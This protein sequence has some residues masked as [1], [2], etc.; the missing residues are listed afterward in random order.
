MAFKNE[1]RDKLLWINKH[2]ESQTLTFD[3]Y[4]SKNYIV[5]ILKF[6][7]VCGKKL[8]FV[9]AG[10]YGTTISGKMFLIPN[11]LSEQFI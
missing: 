1:S 2:Y 4:V 3:F 10:N 7:F 5:L 9:M 8:N 11:R 6:M